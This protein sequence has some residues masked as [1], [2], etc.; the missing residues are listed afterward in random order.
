MAV[1]R[2]VGDP[3]MTHMALQP[4]LEDRD[5]WLRWW[6]ENHQLYDSDDLVPSPSTG[7]LRFKP[8]NE[9]VAL[10]LQRSSRPQSISISTS[11]TNALQSTSERVTE[12]IIPYIT[13]SSKEK[14]SPNAERQKQVWIILFAMVSFVFGACILWLLKCKSKR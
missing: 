1:S 3:P 6:N 5:E 2:I 4:T 8:V 11:Q 7:S 14:H 12:T 9:R 10:E 13:K